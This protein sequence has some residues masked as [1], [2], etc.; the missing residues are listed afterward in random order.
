MVEKT[1]SPEDARK[2]NTEATRRRALKGLGALAGVA[3]YEVFAGR[4][5]PQKLQ[6]I[7]RISVEDALKKAE[8]DQDVSKTPLE[9]TNS[10]KIDL[11]WMTQ[12]HIEDLLGMLYHGHNAGALIAHST[13]GWKYDKHGNA[14][15]ER[16]PWGG[17]CTIIYNVHNYPRETGGLK[18]DVITLEGLIVAPSENKI[19][20]L[21]ARKAG[22]H[23]DMLLRENL[24]RPTYIVDIGPSGK[25]LLFLIFGSSVV[26]G[27]MA[28]AGLS[29][30]LNDPASLLSP[31]H[32][33]ISAYLMSET[34]TGAGRWGLFNS[35]K[36][37]RA[38]G[39]LVKTIDDMPHLGM[40]V[41]QRL[42]NVLAAE[43]NDYIASLYGEQLGRPVHL[44]TEWG[45]MHVGLETETLRSSA[46]RV[47]TLNRWKKLI[48]LA[49]VDP[50]EPSLLWTCPRVVHDIDS[51]NNI[52]RKFEPPHIEVPSLKKL[53]AEE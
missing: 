53:F 29:K 17:R 10:E 42:R 15:I 31:R 51:H 12:E 45:V 50:N 44:T 28:M 19:E 39:A 49:C 18:A 34:I 47:A 37:L 36:A 11:S 46:E 23:E 1:P 8:K 43:K 4:A 16:A 27:T 20:D 3:A 38:T 35:R 9:E 48:L 7:P 5:A 26:T 40:L 6:N 14:Y 30:I 25:Q 41:L 33:A 24:D 21:P 13:D 32:S 2:S 22:R 52:T